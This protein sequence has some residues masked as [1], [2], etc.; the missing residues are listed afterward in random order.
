MNKK[1]LLRAFVLAVLTLPIIYG[2]KR[3]SGTFILPFEKLLGITRVD[4]SFLMGVWLVMW[5]FSFLILGQLSQFIRFNLLFLIGMLTTALGLFMTSFATSY[6]WLLIWF[7]V[8]SGLGFGSASFFTNATSIYDVYEHRGLSTGFNSSILIAGMAGF[9][10]GLSWL[11]EKVFGL[12]GT[13]QA[14]S[15]MVA[16]GGIVGYFLVSKEKS[17]EVGFRFDSR[18]VRFYIAVALAFGVYQ[19]QMIHR[20]PLFKEL[21][22][23][24]SWLGILAIVDLWVNAGTEFVAGW[25]F[26]DKLKNSRLTWKV[27]CLAVILGNIGLIALGRHYIGFT[28]YAFIFG[29]VALMPT[30]IL[31]STNYLADYNKKDWGPLMGTTLFF[32]NIAMAVFSWVGGAFYQWFGSYELIFVITSGIMFICA[33]LLKR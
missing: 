18:L 10:F 3:N 5:A 24:L 17:E 4:S 12:A 20:L 23:S 13:F 29:I 1:S 6:T 7:S 32:A 21:G 27:A 28:I 26:I 31:P 9:L 2:I 19:M 30:L 25:F 8:V 16:F 22:I 14:L 11:I 15:F 33:F